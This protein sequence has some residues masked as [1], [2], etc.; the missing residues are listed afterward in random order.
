[1]CWFFMAWTYFL[2]L[3]RIHGPLL[4]FSVY[5]ELNNDNNDDENTNV[6]CTEPK[7]LLLSLKHILPQ[8][9]SQRYNSLALKKELKNNLVFYFFLAKRPS[10]KK[11]QRQMSQNTLKINFISLLLLEPATV[12]WYLKSIFYSRFPKVS[13]PSHHARSRFFFHAFFSF[14]HL[15]FFLHNKWSVS[16]CKFPHLEVM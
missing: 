4:L 14:S 8:T 1:M 5:L 6:T 10:M 11:I 3:C 12:C 2:S 16:L 9:W 7:W 13:K 15:I